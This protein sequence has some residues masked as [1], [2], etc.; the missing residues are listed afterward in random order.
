MIEIDASA[1]EGGGQVL[2]SSLSLSLLTG[3]P[4]TLTGIRGRRPKPGLMRQHLTC[5]QAAQAIAPGAEVQ[6]AELGSQQLRF[7]PAPVQPGAYRFEIATAGSCL[8][9]LQTVWL[10]L[11]MASGASELELSG[12]THNPMAPPFPFIEQAFAPLLARLGAPAELDLQRAGFYPAGGGRLKVRIPPA[13][14]LQPF[15]L[16]EP[17]ALITR[18]AQAVA[19]GLPRS[20]AERELQTLA[21]MLDWPGEALEVLPCRQNEGPGNALWAR[22]EHEALTELFCAFGEKGRTA[23]D[24]AREVAREV[25]HH[26]QTGA[27]LGPQLADQ[28][29]LPL[30][31][32]VSRSG[33]GA[34]FSASAWTE[35]AR[36]NAGLIERFLPVVMHVTKLQGN[37]VRVE[38]QPRP[39]GQN[40]R[41]DPPGTRPRGSWFGNS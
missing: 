30:A 35:H 2:R 21:G 5:V 7:V 10:P 28:W 26:L 32:A 3:T 34:T 4:I 18:R 15:D 38:L 22:L 20:I 1:G 25:R 12:G 36:T 14:P 29:L 33:K 23:E 9:V 27:A 41:P 6:G 8:L 13:A 17:G 37:A 16:V 19:P 11:A 31:L 40:P 24:V 39:L